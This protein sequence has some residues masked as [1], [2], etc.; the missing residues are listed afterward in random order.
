MGDT[1]INGQRATTIGPT[2]P[3]TTTPKSAPVTPP[4]PSAPERP[5][6]QAGTSKTGTA[7]TAL[8][9]DAA[10]AKA[11]KREWISP[12]PKGTVFI[13][14]GY[15]RSAYTNSDIR[16]KGNGYDFTLHDA[17]ARDKPSFGTIGNWAQ[18][19]L[20]TNIDV[21]QT[22]YRIGYMINDRTWIGFSGDHMKYKMK[23]Q[24]VKITGHVSPEASKEFAGTF[25]G[26]TVAVGKPGTIL[27]DLQHCDGLNNA[28]IEVGTFLPIAQ[29]RKG[30]MSLEGYGHI[31][32]GVVI[33]DTRANV[34]SRTE[35]GSIDMGEHGHENPNG[36]MSETGD[37]SHRHTHVGFILDGAGVSAG[38]GMR[39]TFFKRAF[40]DAGIKGGVDRLMGF[41][42]HDEGKG[43]QT[44]GFIQPNLQIGIQHTFGGK[45]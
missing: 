23:E 16:M 32:A 10:P 5:A 40:I 9:L 6:D 33:T 25:N 42:S 36:F 20:K 19:V 27:S 8:S 13:S 28:F 41:H 17:T 43:Y 2:P 39:A 1:V 26:E 22:N 4:A 30:S 21:P 29:N 3:P 45:K 37:H 12:H 44:I 31:G 34:F 7:T 15:N 38:V 35:D 24:N 18:N 11:A 14:Y